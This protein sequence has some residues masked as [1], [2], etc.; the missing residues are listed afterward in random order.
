MSHD[1]QN[2]IQCDIVRLK[3]HNSEQFIPLE[4]VQQQTTMLWRG[5]QKKIQHSL[6]ENNL[7]DQH[8]DGSGSNARFEIQSGL[9]HSVLNIDMLG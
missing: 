1:A 5:H 4:C 7:D 9:N 6:L 3:Q 8:V 2:S